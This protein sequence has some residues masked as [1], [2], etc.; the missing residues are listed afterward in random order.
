LI[1]LKF[2]GRGGQGV[3]TLSELFARAAAYEGKSVQSVPHFGA[4]RRGASVVAYTRVSEEKIWLREPVLQPDV[5]VALDSSLVIENGLYKDVKTGGTIVLNTSKPPTEMKAR[6]STHSQV[7]YTVDATGIALKVLEKP[8]ISTP[9]LGALS[10][11]LGLTS[12]SSIKRAIQFGFPN[13]NVDLDM[14]SV[15]TAMESTMSG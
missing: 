7:L 8:I 11:A 9:M 6:M 10:T 1:E 2:N 3:V 4:E 15:K 12:L 13:K 14:E 5:L